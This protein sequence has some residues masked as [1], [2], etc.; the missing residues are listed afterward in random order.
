MPINIPMNSSFS[1]CFRQRLR[2][3]T[4]LFFLLLAGLT[5]LAQAQFSYITNNGT[6]T[7]TSYYGTASDVII[8]DTLNGY[9]VAD[10]AADAFNQVD[11]MI[12]LSISTN[13]TTLGTNFVFQCSALTGA[14]IPTSVTNIGDGPFFDCQSFVGVATFTN[15]YYTATNGLLLNRAQTSLIQFP[16]GLTVSY[17]VPAA[18]TNVNEAFI[19]NTLTTLTVD[20]ANANY[21]ATNGVLFN[22]NKTQLVAYPGNLAGSYVV[23]TNTT[24]ILSGAF[25]YSPAVT[26]VSIGTNVTYIGY[27]AFYDCQ[28]MTAITVNA[29]NAFFSTTNGVLFDKNKNTLI[30]FPAAIGGNYTIPNTVSNI[31]DG[32]FGDAFSLNS[33]YIPDGV[34]NLGFEAFYACENL[35]G[36]YIGSKVKTIGAA[37]F[38]LCQ[39]L[40]EISFP[41]SVSSIGS[42]AIAN[43]GAL[44]YAC[45]QGS[46]PAD[47]GSIFYYDN[48]LNTILYVSTSTGWGATYDGITTAPCTACLGTEPTQ[49]ELYILRSGTNVVLGWSSSFTGYSLEYTTNLVPLSPW[50]TNTPAPVILNSLYVATNGITGTRKFY[51]LIQ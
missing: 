4:A 42:E 20:P 29:T 33:V 9:K 37:A 47:G 48:I 16:C 39:N 13:V 36:V 40:S 18:I 12:S 25:E 6:V 46:P 44:S 2:F 31:G 51:R 3:R 19:G 43:C 10:I 38:F 28:G 11:T 32:A 1:N 50:K 23:P 45:F 27:G 30:Q 26:G 35:S 5:G 49:P 17:N 22:K 21:T 7:I 34:T 15:A 14:T 24:A 41:A 8:P